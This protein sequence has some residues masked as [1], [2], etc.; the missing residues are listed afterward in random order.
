MNNNNWIDQEYRKQKKNQFDTLCYEAIICTQSLR[1]QKGT[2]EG[3]T[4]LHTQLAIQIQRVFAIPVLPVGWVA[5]G[6]N[7]AT[8]VRLQIQILVVIS[9]DCTPLAVIF[10]H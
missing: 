6:T 7:V 8:D 2:L 1:F 5:T 9:S 4:R 10:I 3:T